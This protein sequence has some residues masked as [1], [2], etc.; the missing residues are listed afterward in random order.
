M[1]GKSPPNTKGLGS[2]DTTTLQSLR[3]QLH[4]ERLV[5]CLENDLV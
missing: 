3:G 1:K 4:R 2:M 5:R